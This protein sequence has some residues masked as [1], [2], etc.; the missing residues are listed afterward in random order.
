MVSLGCRHLWTVPN[1][2]DIFPIE[3]IKLRETLYR[4]M[5]NGEAASNNNFSYSLLCLLLPIHFSSLV[6]SSAVIT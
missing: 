2:I 3:T 4:T 1:K 6:C 5:A